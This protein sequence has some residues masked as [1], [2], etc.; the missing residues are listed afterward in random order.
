MDSL[1]ALGDP[2]RLMIVEYLLGLDDE[3]QLRHPTNLEL[4]SALNFQDGTLSKRIKKLKEAG[5]V[6]PM[7]GPRKD[8]PRYGLRHPGG[9]LALLRTAT[10]LDLAISAELALLKNLETDIKADRLRRLDA[11]IGKK[12]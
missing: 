3:S 6:V 12:A 8:Q 10:E 7:P 9:L 2:T 11:R 1:E 4:A 5:L